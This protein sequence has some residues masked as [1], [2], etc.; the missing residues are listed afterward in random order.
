MTD[1]E[2]TEDQPAQR[3]VPDINLGA[4]IAESHPGA[5]TTK[6]AAPATGGAKK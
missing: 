4:T 6:A 2:K 3:E 1:P 5:G